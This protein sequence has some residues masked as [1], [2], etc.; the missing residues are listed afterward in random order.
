MRMGI[1][2]VGLG[3]VAAFS[4]GAAAHAGGGF[5]YGLTVTPTPGAG[6]VAQVHSTLGTTYDYGWSNLPAY[7]SVT[8]WVTLRSPDSSAPTCDSYVF[9]S[10]AQWS[11]EPVTAGTP[12]QPFTLSMV[13]PVR[14]DVKIVCTYANANPVPVTLLSEAAPVP[15]VAS[16]PSP[17]PAA[18]KPSASTPAPAPSTQRPAAPPQAPAGK[19]VS[20]VVPPAQLA[21]SPA[22][23]PP[24]SAAPLPVAVVA[25]APSVSPTPTP[26]AAPSPSPAT[27]LVD[28]LAASVSPVAVTTPAAPAHGGSPLPLLLGAIVVLG[29]GAFAV[30]RLKGRDPLA[31][32][33]RQDENKEDP[34]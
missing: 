27:P 20:V 31:A 21:A 17:T 4:L 25:P 7:V 24:S 1:L 14:W 34:E 19:A 5:D 32:Y 33:V 8:P 13:S 30:A 16:T 28:A 10:G 26:S 2:A 3:L 23:V 6:S 18:P 12:A 11:A 29:I 22:P 15:V 9:R